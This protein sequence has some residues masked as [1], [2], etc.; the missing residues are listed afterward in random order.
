[1]AMATVTNAIEAW[2]KSWSTAKGRADRLDPD[3]DV[4]APL[5]G[6]KAR[7]ARPRLRSRPA[8][9]VSRQTGA[10]VGSDRRRRSRSRGHARDR[11]SPQRITGS[12]T[13]NGRRAGFELFPLK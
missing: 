8:L 4:M 13:R 11:A 12:A 6:L 10:R 7:S 1:M 2:D 3:P 9:G 5:P